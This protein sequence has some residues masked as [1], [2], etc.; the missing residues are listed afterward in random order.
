MYSTFDLEL[1]QL[2]MSIVDGNAT[3]E[4]NQTIWYTIESMIIIYIVT[5]Q[6]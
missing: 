4:I 6:N 1:H 3:R 2:C 5:L